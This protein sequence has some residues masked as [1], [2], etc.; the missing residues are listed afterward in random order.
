[1]REI[2]AHK[3]LWFYILSV[4]ECFPVDEEDIIQ[5]TELSQSNSRIN[6]VIAPQA[7]P[8]QPNDI[9][10]IEKKGEENERDGECIWV[11]TIL[12]LLSINRSYHFLIL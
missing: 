1:M 9:L 3:S 2:F 7:L 6:N 5:N 10:F 4:S 12:S 11:L 8:S